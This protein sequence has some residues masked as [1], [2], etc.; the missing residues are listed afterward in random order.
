MLDKY[1]LLKKEMNKFKYL[2]SDKEIRKELNIIEDR[3]TALFL[4]DQRRKK[5]EKIIKS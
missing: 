4:A 3:I 2:I 5:L 1:D